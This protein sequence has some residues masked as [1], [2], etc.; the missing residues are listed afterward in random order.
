MLALC[1]W[2]EVERF[3]E[4]FSGMQQSDLVLTMDQILTKYVLNDRGFQFIPGMREFRYNHLLLITIK[5]VLHL[6]CGEVQYWI[7]QLSM[8]F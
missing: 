2:Q 1:F 3:R 4:E 7:F 5:S 8:L 6:A